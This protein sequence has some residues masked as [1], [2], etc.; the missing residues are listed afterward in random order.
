M[1]VVRLR[2]LLRAAG[3]ETRVGAGSACVIFGR[4]KTEPVQN[5]VTANSTA[6]PMEEKGPG[7]MDLVAVKL[8]P[9]EPQLWPLRCLLRCHHT[10]YT[11]EEAR[12]MQ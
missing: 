2:R 3:S 4:C 6:T 9:F 8:E 11:G 12:T 5:E 7:C 10:N 1:V